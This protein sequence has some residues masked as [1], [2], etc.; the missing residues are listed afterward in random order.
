MIQLCDISFEY[1]KKTVFSHL[2]L[3][4]KKGERVALMGPSGCGKSTL[5]QLI[6]GLERLS[7]ENGT[8]SVNAQKIAYAFQEPRL[9][10]WLTVE[11][12]LEPILPDGTDKRVIKE[13]LAA[14]DLIDV[15]PLYP[16]QLSGGMASRV[17]L[18]RA[19]L[20]DA[21]LILLDEPFTALDKETKEGIIPYLK[22]T[23][24]KKN[25]TVLLVTHQNTEA[26]ALCDR[27]LNFEEL[28][29]KTE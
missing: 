3:S 19:L 16:D 23:F 29:P 27:V 25:A 7:G 21:D 9:F 5:L 8:L 26:E 12:N 14:L 22:E 18:A 11:K 15:A 28:L 4:V 10:P 1:G 13:T 24:A 17:S 2:S 20:Y 6:A